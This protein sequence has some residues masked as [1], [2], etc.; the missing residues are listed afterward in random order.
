MKLET[1]IWYEI[2][3]APNFSGDRARK[4]IHVYIYTC[5]QIYIT[6]TYKHV[7]IYIHKLVHS[8]MHVHQYRNILESWVHTNTF[9]F[10]QSPQTSS[11]PFSFYF[12]ICLLPLETLDP[13]YINSS[14]HCS[15][16]YISKVVPELLHPYQHKN[17]N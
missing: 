4:H 11:L 5:I 17:Q 14:L 15:K 9:N 16:L 13:N 8:H 6:H 10:N 3:F 12:S 1:K 2:I 7:H